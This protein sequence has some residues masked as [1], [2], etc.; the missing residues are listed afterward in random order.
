MINE[1]YDDIAIFIASVYGIVKSFFI[2]QNNKKRLIKQSVEVMKT[3]E[4]VYLDKECVVHTKSVDVDTKSVDVDTKSVDVD[5][6][7]VVV[8]TKSVVVDTKSVV[9]DTKSVVVDTKCVDTSDNIMND[10]WS[11]GYG[12]ERVKIYHGHVTLGHSNDTSD[13]DDF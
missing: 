11:V 6:K 12:I 2:Q 10:S 5:T 8:D 4:D 1:N 9:V 13:D 3:L 7:S